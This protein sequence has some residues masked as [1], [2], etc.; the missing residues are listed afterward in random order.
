MPSDSAID[1]DRLYGAHDL[2]ELR[3]EYERIA[4]DYDSGLV[5]GMGY[6]SP[7]AVAVIVRE[8][9][10]ADAHI[11]DVGVGTGLLGVALAE[12]GFTR[13]DGMDLSPGML[14]EAA[15]KHVYGEL[16]E[17][18]L[19]GPLEYATSEYD[20]V[21][22]SGVS[23]RACA[24]V[25]PDELVRITRGPAGM[26]IFTLRSDQVPPG[27]ETK[28]AALES[29]PL[30]AHRARG[31]VPGL[32]DGRAGC[33]GP[34]LGVPRPLG[35]VALRDRSPARASAAGLVELLREGVGESVEARD[36]PADT[37][38]VN[39]VREAEA[40]V[41]DRSEAGQLDAGRARQGARRQHAARERGIP[42]VDEQRRRRL[43]WLEHAS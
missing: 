4:S 19:G 17:G 18:R 15:R 23:P 33:P 6:C 36:D 21:V 16:R 22:A 37:V 42:I 40:F 8:R 39:R 31:R 24:C 34:R 43:T 30:G 7:A 5:D 35:G 12:A 38:V 14:A 29:E 20:G 28:I 10:G 27:Y 26:W 25:V 32:A 41:H 2:D 13:L 1:L 11:L 9:L 3:G